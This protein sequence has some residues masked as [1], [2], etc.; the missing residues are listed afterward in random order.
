MNIDL[1]MPNGRYILHNFD[2]I[3]LKKIKI[4]KIFL[5]KIKIKKNFLK[6]LQ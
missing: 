5:K 1:N 6:K 2:L 3:F 4:K